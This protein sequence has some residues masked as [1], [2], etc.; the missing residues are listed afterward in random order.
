MIDQ[1]MLEDLGH[2]VSRQWLNGRQVAYFKLTT[3]SQEAVDTWFE[4]L[5]DVI[6]HW[7]PKTP[8]LV[9]HDFSACG[10]S[11]YSLNRMTEVRK[12]APEGL[13]G[14]IIAIVPNTALGRLMS[15]FAAQVARPY[16]GKMQIRT[17]VTYD[18]AL[19]WAEELL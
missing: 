5:K 2:G 14:R 16:K 13:S 6:S 18:E 17:F 9:I 4:S 19:A 15:G 12:H 1:F 7:D 3:V 11:R 10:F 8:Y